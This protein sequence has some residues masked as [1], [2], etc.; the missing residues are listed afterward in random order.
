[1]TIKSWDRDDDRG[2]YIIVGGIAL[3]IFFMF[4]QKYFLQGL[5]GACEI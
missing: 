1:M 2:I 3:F 4:V 5:M